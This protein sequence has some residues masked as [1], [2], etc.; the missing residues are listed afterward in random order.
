MVWQGLSRKDAAAKA[1]ISEHGLYQA[2]RKPLVKQHYLGELEVLRTSERARNFHA[3]VEVRDQIGNPMA[4][5][6]AVKEME[7]HE[8]LSVAS[9]QPRAGM[10]IVVMQAPQAQPAEP[11]HQVIDVSPNDAS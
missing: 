3:L 7:H 10:L 5:V 6:N 11:V 2:F 4:R 1:A 8:D 9:S